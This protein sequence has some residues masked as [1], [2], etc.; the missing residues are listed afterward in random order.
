M[1]NSAASAAAEAA[2]A[3]AFADMLMAG[4]LTF[5]SLER[6][7]LAESHAIMARAMGRALERLDAALRA[8]LPSG[9]RVRDVR[10]RSPATVVGDVSFR[11]RRLR[12]K[13]EGG[14]CVPLAGELDL[15]WG[16]RVSPAAEEF[17]VEAAAE[18]PCAAAARPLA[19]AGGSRVSA[20]KVMAAVHA[21]DST[22]VALRGTAPGEP[23]KVEVKA[24]AAYSGKAER[25]RK[26]A[27][28]RCVR[29]GCACA[30]GEFRLEAV[31]AIGSESD[32]SA[33]ERVHL[34]TDGEGWRKR[35]GAYFPLR[36]EVGGHLDPFHVARALLSCFDDAAMGWQLVEVVND[37]GKEA[38]AALLEAC[39]GMGLARKGAPRALAYL[40]RNAD[41]IAVEG[42]S[43]GTMESKSQHPYK[44]RMTPVPCAW[45]RR[46]ASH[47]ARLRSRRGSGRAVPPRTRAG[48]ATLPRRR[49]D[50]GRE[51]AALERGG[52]SAT[53]CPARVGSGYEPPRAS[54]ASSAGEMRY[55]AAVDSGM[56]GIGWQ[57]VRGAL[58]P[59]K[60]RRH[61]IL[62][63]LISLD[64]L[65]SLWYPSGRQQ[66]GI[67]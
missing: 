32:L 36:V 42:P 7:A 11:R 17:L 10:E 57:E 53:G 23:S 16:A 20:K 29:H 54:A 26:T 33:L 58:P 3:D 4:G 63:H 66:K 21:A 27:R 44:S 35:G 52:L 67:P 40:R 49:R 55:A 28:E 31:A 41:L 12:A 60:S 15:P 30:P 50:G 22:W 19:R 13:G 59:S 43:L 24:M 45:S 25:G 65:R 61:L 14:A 39:I 51:M 1:D 6:G 64:I 56:A 38:A 48:S 9:L 62:S 18:V 46:G 47:M 2:M 37:G 5:A 8:E 34:G